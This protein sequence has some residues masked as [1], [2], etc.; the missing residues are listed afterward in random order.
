MNGQSIAFKQQVLLETDQKAIHQRVRKML[1]AV[2][3]RE[4]KKTHKMPLVVS[5]S[6][7]LSFE[8]VLTF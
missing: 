3:R 7:E 5:F 8:G 4:I 2:I 1:I 6:F